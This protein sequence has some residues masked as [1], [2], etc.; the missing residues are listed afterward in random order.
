MIHNNLKFSILLAVLF[1]ECAYNHFDERDIVIGNY[2]GIQVETYWRDSIS[3]F[4]KDSSPVNIYLRK[5]NTESIIDFFFSSVNKAPDF[6]FTYQ[7]GAFKS[8]NNFHPAQLNLLQD[9]LYFY[10][11]QGL[12]PYWLECFSKKK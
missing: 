6:R 9:S 1:M 8:L 12:G 5:S 2:Y 10:Y 4:Q 7:N 11:K 3:G